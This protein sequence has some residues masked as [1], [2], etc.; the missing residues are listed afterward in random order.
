MA[1]YKLGPPSLGLFTVERVSD[2]GTV[3]RLHCSIV[4]AEKIV[5]ALNLAE[6]LADQ[7]QAFGRGLPNWHK[8][9]KDATR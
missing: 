7:R 9:A 5:K 8:A 4:I 1:T 2:G 6:D 3:A